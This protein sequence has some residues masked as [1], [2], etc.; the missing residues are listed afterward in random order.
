MAWFK[1]LRLFLKISIIVALAIFSFATNIIYNAFGIVST[2]KDLLL[3]EEKLYEIVQLASINSVLLSR[4]DELLTQAVSF[5]DEELKDSAIEQLKELD[6]NIE[7][8]HALDAEYKREIDELENMVAAYVSVSVEIVNSMLDGNA[9]MSLIA[10]KATN[11]TQ[12]FEAANTLLAAYKKNVDSRFIS[13]ISGARTKGEA[14]LTFSIIIGVVLMSI[15]LVVALSVAKSISG[16][17]NDLGQSLDEL[18]SGEGNLNHRVNVPGDDELGKVA[19]HF[20]RFM[21]T[22]L[23][24]VKRVLGLCSPLADSSKRL[25]KTSAS[26]RELME[27]QARNAQ[28]AGD[29]MH[30]FRNSIQEITESAADAR[31]AVLE[32]EEEINMGLQIVEKTIS[33]SVEFGQQINQAAQSV[34]D[35]AQY[36][37]SVNSILDVIKSISEQTNLLALNAAIEAARA[38]EQ[39]RGF[40][41]VADEV[42]TLASRSGEATTEIFQVLEKLRS[43]ATHSVELMTQSQEKSAIN[44]QYSKDTGL[45]L[46]KIRKR[47][48]S[49]TTLNEKI[50]TSTSDQNHVIAELLKT[51]ETMNSSVSECKSSFDELDS[52]AHELHQTSESLSE[53][54]G[55]F[56]L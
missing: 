23:V 28:F 16:T 56:R 42:R 12:F 25:L 52:M 10:K 41:V 18:A 7:K 9:D 31:S 55:K 43:N 14:T 20:N 15:L 49:I 19:T 45:A 27:E 33:N 6:D 30:D 2:H 50:A 36:T 3:V 21:E 51:V 24:A 17:A 53:A 46:E 39:G 5:D 1:N 4:S 26:A 29:S 32:S 8:L 11:K 34:N 37:I 54:T 35:L 48:D 44:E 40:A 38:G 13:T 22:L 47:I